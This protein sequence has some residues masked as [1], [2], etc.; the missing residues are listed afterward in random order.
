MRTGAIRHGQTECFRR[1]AHR[2]CRAHHRATA[3]SRT[4]QPFH[5]FIFIR[6][7]LA[8]K[9]LSSHFLEFICGKLAPLIFTRQHRSAGHNNRRNIDAQSRH[10]HCGNDFVAAADQYHAIQLLRIDHHFNGIG[11]DLAAGQHAAHTAVALSETI[12]NGNRVDFKRNATSFANTILDQLTQPIQMNMARMHL[13]VGIDN[14][15]KRF[16]QFLIHI[17]HPAEMCARSRHAQPVY[18]GC[19]AVFFILVVKIKFPIHLARLQN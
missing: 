14:A 19:R 9:Q 11:D 15:D 18:Y 4:H 7:D 12:T 8:A 16:C 5:I 17:S 1:N 6:L 13:I 3:R 10:N 2:I